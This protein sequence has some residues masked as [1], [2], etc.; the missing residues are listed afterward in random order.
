M[1]RFSLLALGVAL[2]GACGGQLQLPDLGGSREQV[3][4]Q[5][6]PDGFAPVLRVN[7][8]A[9]PAEL[10]YRVG[11]IAER[12]SSAKTVLRGFCPGENRV[13]AWVRRGE[14]EL[15]RQ[16]FA[17][18]VPV[19]GA[20][21]LQVPAQV[22]VVDED[23]LEIV[24]AQVADFGC[25]PTLEADAPGV[26][27]GTPQL[28]SRENVHV[29]RLPLTFEQGRSDATLRLR[30]TQG[31]ASAEATV[32]LSRP[33]T[34]GPDP[35]P[36]PTVRVR[37]VGEERVSL[38]Q[39]STL[40]FPA[41]VSATDG[42]STE[43]VYS[44]NAPSVATVNSN[45]E[46]RAVAPGEAV[47]EA[48][49]KA[50]AA[51]KV[52]LL[53]TVTPPP[54]FAL[55]PSSDALTLTAGQ[56]QTI[57]VGLTPSG[58]YSGSATLTTQASSGLSVGPISGQVSASEP[59]T[60]TVRGDAVGSHDLALL[61]TDSAAS[62]PL[63]ANATIRVTVVAPTA[64][65]TDAPPVIQS[66]NLS[67][68]SVIERSPQPVEVHAT[69][70]RGIAS[71]QLWVAGK[72]VQHLA[73]QGNR[74][75]ADWNL[76][77]LPN[78]PVSVQIRVTDTAGQVSTWERT[79]SVQLASGGLREVGRFDL[80]SPPT[81]NVVLSESGDL[82]FVGTGGGLV[83]VALANGA[84]QTLALPSGTVRSLLLHGGTLY[85]VTGDDR[86][87]RIATSSLS[88]VS[89]HL[90]P[91]RATSA[92]AAGPVGVY[93]G[94][95]SG[96]VRADLPGALPHAR[97]QRVSSLAVGERIYAVHANPAGST[98]S[99]LV[100]SGTAL[101]ITRTV[102]AQNL[103]WVRRTESGRIYGSGSGFGP[104]WQILPDLS[105]EATEIGTFEGRVSTVSDIQGVTVAADRDG[106]VVSAGIR[107]KV[108]G[109]VEY[110]MW[111]K[112]DRLYVGDGAGNLTVFEVQGSSLRQLERRSGLGNLHGDLTGDPDGRVVYLSVAG[113]L[114]VYFPQ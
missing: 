29:F 67:G 107:H 43:L 42:V 114:L 56:S 19:A 103:L 108:G 73:L 68:I 106:G 111:H 88:I 78:G 110:G 87:L 63:T 17:L 69:D 25:A 18:S 70:D 26:T 41:E 46:I 1:K 59:M 101:N 35:V 104:L 50:D 55:N 84:M 57:T 60:L 38:P 95:E 66:V 96:V 52:R 74:Y 81:S 16:T 2:L 23:A 12:A 32:S 82:A 9:Q 6:Q 40:K 24:L 102:P 3:S 31:A 5:L 39:G 47:L 92:L 71:V 22:E 85:A 8:L 33:A 34:P 36:A 100:P 27:L 11:D 10:W 105:L 109:R 13:E 90:L 7:G 58:G 98:L 21:N 94:T 20:L 28:V 112:G 49:A 64:P 75:R 77:S 48:A 4:L 53:L 99:E 93:V 54:S 62:P 76:S 14:R 15:A 72:L 79:V 86:L 37:L 89:E 30:V 51:Q 45:G 97:G 65:P 44:T 91:A 80:P 113:R 83:S 61:A